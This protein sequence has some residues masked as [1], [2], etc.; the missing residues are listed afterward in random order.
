MLKVTPDKVIPKEKT[1]KH[2]MS[3][4]DMYAHTSWS[5]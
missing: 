4:P 3:S 2:W 1:A 5:P